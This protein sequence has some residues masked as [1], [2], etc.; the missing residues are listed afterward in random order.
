MGLMRTSNTYQSAVNGVDVFIFTESRRR[1]FRHRIINF[2]FFDGKRW[3]QADWE[4]TRNMRLLR[5]WVSDMH[6]RVLAS[7]QEV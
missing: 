3:H 4:T 2:C 1:P 7:S 6:E 5:Q